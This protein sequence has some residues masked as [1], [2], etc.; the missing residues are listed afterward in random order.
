M[1][2]IP[3]RTEKSAAGLDAMCRWILQQIIL[4]ETRDHP[5]RTFRGDFRMAEV[6]VWTGAG[7][8][9]FSR[10]FLKIFAV[11]P[12][13]A[14]PEIAG[15][16]D[17]KRVEGIFDGRFIGNGKVVKVKL[18]SVRAANTIDDESLDMVYIDAIHAYE[19]VKTDIL[20][21]L[22]KVRK[23]GF[24]CGHDYEKRFPGVKAAVDEFA[25]TTM[26]GMK[27]FPDS[28]WAIKL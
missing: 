5:D 1:E 14:G 17:M 10:Y 21:W 25:I 8:K 13:E 3:E 15:L 24:L 18:P 27:T 20:A 16:H 2:Q 11:D 12:W 28:S 26:H 9:I 7:T 23:G 22:P 4:D 6:G 19:G